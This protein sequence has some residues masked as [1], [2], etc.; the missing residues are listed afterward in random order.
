MTAPID[1]AEFRRFCGRFAT[2]VTIVTTMDREGRPAGMTA[3][4]FASVSLEPPLVSL[5]IGHEAT[6]YPAMCDA[7]R[8]T[9][10]ILDSRQEALSRRFAES[11]PERFDGIGWQQSAERHVLID[12]AL[13][14]ICCRKWRTFEAGDHTIFVG[15]VTGGSVAEHGEPLLYYRGGYTEAG[16]G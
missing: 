3:T 10:N 8:F 5:A 11:L 12:G 13:G 2:G 7:D 4:S 6:I 14:H 9:V 1:A 16:T 15:E